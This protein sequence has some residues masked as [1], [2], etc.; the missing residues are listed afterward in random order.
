LR[1][2]LMIRNVF[3]SPMILASEG[4]INKIERSIEQANNLARVNGDVG[5][6]D[7]LNAAAIGLRVKFLECPSFD[8]GL[9]CCGDGAHGRVY[10]R[11]SSGALAYEQESMGKKIACPVT[12][13]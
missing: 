7:D 2:Q 1:V 3:R 4:A 12:I 8:D 9:S 5:G 11:S 10:Y 13:S 6:S